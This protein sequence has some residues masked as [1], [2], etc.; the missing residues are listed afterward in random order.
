[1]TGEREQGSETSKLWVELYPNDW[2]PYNGLANNAVLLGRYESAVGSARK[3]M[4]LGPSQDF[5]SSNLLAALI[6]LNRL[7]EAKWTCQT[8]LACKRP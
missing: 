2:K 8:A 3:A 4:E 5:G 6:A 1:M 7:N